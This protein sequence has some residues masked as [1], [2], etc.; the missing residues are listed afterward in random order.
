MRSSFEYKLAFAAALL[1]AGAPAAGAFEERQAEQ[2]SGPRAGLSVGARA[3]YYRASGGYSGDLMQGAQARYHFTRRWA[4]EASADFRREKAGSARVDVVPLQLSALLYLMPQGY[5]LA[6]YLLAGGGWYY[7]RF[8]APESRDEFLF[9]PH[10]G[11]G[12]EYYYNTAWSADFSCRYQWAE[13][14]HSQDLAH[15]LGRNL[16]GK[17]VMFTLA[18]NYSF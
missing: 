11:G 7:T 17:G 5:R 10:A 13:D 18:V 2:S 9:G 16:S 3:A 12:A 4:A 15:P 8:Y 1:L 6:P 14:P